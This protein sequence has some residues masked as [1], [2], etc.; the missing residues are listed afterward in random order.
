VRR[1][2]SLLAI[3]A[4]CGP[5]A[6]ARAPPIVAPIAS[7]PASATGAPRPPKGPP[8][9]PRITVAFF[10]PSGSGAWS[11]AI[12]WEPKPAEVIEECYRRAL[13]DDPEV[14]GWLWVE[15]GGIAPGASGAKLAESSPLPPTLTLCIVQRLRKVGVPDGFLAPAG[16]F[17]V[18][19]SS[20][21]MAQ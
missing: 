2:L 11:D 16:R 12:R 21:P 14:A 3:L 5:S 19:L 13:E 20:F 10:D 18:N 15:A 1:R 9:N 8:R 4:G 6:P 7:A 17:F